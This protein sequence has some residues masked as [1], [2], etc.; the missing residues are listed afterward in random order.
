MCNFVVNTVPTDGLIIR[1]ARTSSDTVMTQFIFI[2]ELSTISMFIWVYMSNTGD[3]FVL[4]NACL[5]WISGCF[6]ADSCVME[7]RSNKSNYNRHKK[8][9]QRRTLGPIN[10]TLLV[11]HVAIS[12]KYQFLKLIALV[13][14]RNSLS[15]LEWISDYI[16]IRYN[17]L[18]PCDFIGGS[19]QRPSDAYMRQ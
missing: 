16:V 18:M 14:Y 13:L 2:Q 6:V 11:V 15:K 17:S 12:S 19:T 5:W 4:K 8:Q 1:G 7:D 10:T 9:I 3:Y